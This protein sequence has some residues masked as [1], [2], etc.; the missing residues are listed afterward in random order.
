MGAF[1]HIAGARSR[2][3]RHGGIAFSDDA[4]LG[5]YGTA[6]INETG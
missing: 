1:R 2:E 6:R 4:T 3:R 5:S